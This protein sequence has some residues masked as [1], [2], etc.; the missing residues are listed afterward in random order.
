MQ[1]RRDQLIREPSHDPTKPQRKFAD[2]TVCPD[3]GA[4]FRDGRWTW[5]H[6]PV[7]AP[8]HRC[9]ACER[10]R[11][12]YPAGFVTLTGRFALDH[13]D[14]IVR[15]ARNTE[16]F[17]QREHP[18]KRIMRTSSTGDE[19]VFETTELHLAQAIG[20]AVQRAF[21]GQ[22][23]VSF[24]EDIVRVHWTRDSDLETAR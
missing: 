20:R 17:E 13:R 9:S 23:E 19:L 15:L 4:T 24:D 21:N 22:L 1:K 16:A 12:G 3:C 18:I 8:R 7:D 14:E 6:G 11:D 2:P 5:K 10:I